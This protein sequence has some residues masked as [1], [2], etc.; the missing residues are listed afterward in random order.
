MPEPDQQK[1]I[2]DDSLESQLEKE[3]SLREED[4]ELDAESPDDSVVGEEE[5]SPVENEAESDVA[6]ADPDSI[7]AEFGPIKRPGSGMESNL[8]WGQSVKTGSRGSKKKTIILIVVLLLVVVGGFLLLKSNNSVKKL[9]SAPTPSPTPSSTP[10]PTEIP[11]TLD[12]AQWSLEVLNGSG[13]SGLAKKIGDKLKEL[14]Y[15]VIKTGNADNQN[16]Q[17]TQIFVKSDLKD[18]TDLVIADLRDIIKIASYAG[19]IK[20]STASA[21]IIIGKDSI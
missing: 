16:Y 5:S 12:K 13:E 17:K 1:N 6:G 11:N 9:I 2:E 18:K 14:G 10:A 3:D 20:D 7:G 21:R 4:S 19:E 15:P 8:N